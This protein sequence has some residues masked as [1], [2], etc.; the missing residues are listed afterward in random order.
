VCTSSPVKTV[1]LLTHDEAP[2]PALMILKNL[3]RQNIEQ[4]RCKRNDVG[5][6]HG[7]HTG[8]RVDTADDTD[9]A[10]HRAAISDH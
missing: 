6:H 9:V 7:L 10:L 2:T 8:Q 5:Q 4:P 1:N 3:A